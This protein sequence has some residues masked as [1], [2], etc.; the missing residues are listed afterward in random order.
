MADSAK[1]PIDLNWVRESILADRDL[2]AVLAKLEALRDDL[3]A[4]Q[5]RG[6]FG[7]RPLRSIAQWAATKT[8]RAWAELHDRDRKGVQEGTLLY[9]FLELEEELKKPEK[10]REYVFL[11]LILEVLI[12]VLLKKLGI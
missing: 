3:D 6:A 11:R 4:R 2:G 12:A 9:V 5:A 1:Q 7:R 8:G 10:Q